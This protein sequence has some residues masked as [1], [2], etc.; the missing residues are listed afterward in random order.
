[1]SVDEV[2]TCPICGSVLDEVF[3]DP[4]GECW[5]YSA[6]DGEYPVMLIDGKVMAFKHGGNKYGN[7]EYLVLHGH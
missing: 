4:Y 7:D 6:V 5:F 1:M 2:F 3:W